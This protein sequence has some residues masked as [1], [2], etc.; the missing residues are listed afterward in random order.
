MA[1]LHSSA[2]ATGRHPL[3]D[4]VH[5]HYCMPSYKMPSQEAIWKPKKPKKTQ[6]NARHAT[7][8]RRPSEVDS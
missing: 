3:F 5:G 7:A 8:D 6:A 2:A 1:V 4:E